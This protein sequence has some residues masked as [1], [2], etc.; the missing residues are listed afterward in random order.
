M[1]GVHVAKIKNRYMHK[2][3]SPAERNKFHHYLIYHDK[4]TGNNV[5]V[6]TTHLYVKDP[7]RFKQLK[8]GMGIKLS[9]P[10]LETPSMVTKKMYITNA[11]DKPIDFA[12]RDVRVKSKL[13]KS[14]ARK[15]Y[16]YV[17]SAR[18]K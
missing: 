8:S 6:Q 2:N 15:V 11:K 18:K 12:H 4:H 16:R 9:L 14:K 17:N 10:G 5:A 13:S 3:A 1:Q 7:K